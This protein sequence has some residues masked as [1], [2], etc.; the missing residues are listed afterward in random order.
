MDID[1][2]QTSLEDDI[3][4][5]FVDF[6]AKAEEYEECDREAL[7][8]LKDQFLHSHRNTTF[9]QHQPISARE[10]QAS[11]PVDHTETQII[12]NAP[13]SVS[14]LPASLDQAQI[15]SDSTG[16]ESVPNGESETATHLPRLLTPPSQGPSPA[17]FALTTMGHSSATTAAEQARSEI[18]DYDPLWAAT[19]GVHEEEL[20]A[21]INRIKFEALVRSEVLRIGDTL[22]MPIEVTRNGA[23]EKLTVE[24]LVRFRKEG[25]LLHVVKAHSSLLQFTSRSRDRLRRP[26]ADFSFVVLNAPDITIPTLH[27]VVGTND[28][29]KHLRAYSIQIDKSQ[30]M[31]LNNSLWQYINVYRQSIQHIG[32][33]H[34]V[35]TAFHFWRMIQD[36]IAK[37]TMVSSRPRRTNLRKH[38]LDRKDRR[39]HQGLFG[40]ITDGVFI[41]DDDEQDQFCPMG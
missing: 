5:K 21:H 24:L 10:A 32:T 15:L 40:V 3:L 16:E 26:M 19:A 8:S 31:P 29:V 37:K 13:S 1:N 4:S 11:V 12:S 39:Y 17:I 30:D 9:D 14:E 6:I 28:I 20:L 34:Y 35:K 41:V 7:V 22:T 23:E 33:L 2:Q 27:A 18:K 36:D 38:N 25:S